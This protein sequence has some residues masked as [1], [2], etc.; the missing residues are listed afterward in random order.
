MFIF[1]DDIRIIAGAIFCQVIII[2]QFIQ[3]NPSMISGNQKWNGA[4]PI[5]VIKDE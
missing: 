5:F 3:S 2:K 1:I 4:V